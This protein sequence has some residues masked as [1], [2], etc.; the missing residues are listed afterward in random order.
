MLTRSAPG[1]H[2]YVPTLRHGLC[3]LTTTHGMPTARASSIAAAVQAYRAVP[4]AYDHVPST[5]GSAG[6]IATNRTSGAVCGTST[7][8]CRPY[9]PTR[10]GS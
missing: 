8:H 6:D 5:N 4:A 3:M 10:P 1:S 2:A 7:Y 9:V